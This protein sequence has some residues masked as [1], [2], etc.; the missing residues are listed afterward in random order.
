MPGS[1]AISR[2]C[3]L[4]TAD[5]L[6]DNDITPEELVALLDLADDVKRCLLYTS[7]AADE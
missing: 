6:R 1:A 7:D 3:H 5:F 4:N 2:S